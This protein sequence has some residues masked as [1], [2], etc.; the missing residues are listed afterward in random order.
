MIGKEQ[1]AMM[2]DGVRI[3]NY[4]RG[5]VVDEDA[6]IEALNSGKVARFVADF[7]TEKMCKAPNAVL[8][9]I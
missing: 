6:M 8:T 7:P 5:E 9:R 1:I 2:K 4:A 3:I